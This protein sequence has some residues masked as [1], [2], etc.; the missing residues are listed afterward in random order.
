MQTAGS[1]LLEDK[2]RVCTRCTGH[3]RVQV[4]TLAPDL[5]AHPVG[6][7]KDGRALFSISGILWLIQ[8][9]RVPSCSL[10]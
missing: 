6:Y 2:S 1:S 3:G 9:M 7:Q 10:T 8:V 5:N 4:P